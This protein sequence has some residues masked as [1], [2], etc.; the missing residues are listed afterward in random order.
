VEPALTVVDPP[1]LMVVL[2]DV[3]LW[4]LQPIVVRPVIPLP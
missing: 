1:K 4:Q 2:V 3:P